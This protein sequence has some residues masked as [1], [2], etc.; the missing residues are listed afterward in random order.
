M[1]LSFVVSINLSFVVLVKACPSVDIW[2]VFEK[3]WLAHALQK[4]L[5]LFTAQNFQ[6][7][8]LSWM[9]FSWHHLFVEHPALKMFLFMEDYLHVK[10]RL[11]PVPSFVK[12]QSGSAHF[13]HP[14]STLKNLKDFKTYRPSACFILSWEL[15]ICAVMT[16][17]TFVARSAALVPEVGSQPSCQDISGLC[18]WSAEPGR[19]SPPML[20]TYHIKPCPAVP[21]CM[22]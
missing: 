14:W 13:L 12:S 11:S 4:L 16:W 17:L 7:L 5:Q 6:R 18:P 22:G 3:P 15:S 8:P 9:I 20:Q 2:Y 10:L 1:E 19:C 21:C